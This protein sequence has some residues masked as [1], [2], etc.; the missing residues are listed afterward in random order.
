MGFIGLICKIIS[1]DIVSSTQNYAQDMVASGRGED[2]IAVVAARQS[3][4]RGRYRRNWVSNAGNLYVSFIYKSPERDPKVSYAVAVAIA[5]VLIS[6]G[7]SPEIKWPNDILIDGKKVSGTLI[8]YA[9]DF[10]IVGIGINIESNPTS[11]EY[12]TAKLNDY[13]HEKISP[14]DVLSRLIKSLDLWMA[15]DFFAVRTRWMD[16]SANINSVVK[17]RGKAAEFMGLNDD[18]AMVL[19]NDGQYFLV[20]G[21]ELS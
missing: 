1:L 7:I 4:G 20:Y 3:A 12:E 15:R 2:K 5:E 16:M 18:G 13:A 11:L 6:F 21:D 19:R 8:E 9:G 14:K 10:M 17:Y